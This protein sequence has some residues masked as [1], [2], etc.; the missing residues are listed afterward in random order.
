MLLYHWSPRARR[1]SI[2]LQGL[3]PG[4]LSTDEVWNPPYVCFARSPSRG[5]GLSGMTAR[6]EQHEEWD[7]WMCELDEQL[8][9]ELEGKEWRARTAVSPELLWYVATRRR[10]DG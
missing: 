8:L 9:E 3:V 5:W 10:S 7:L 1:E 6:G 4:S 2:Q